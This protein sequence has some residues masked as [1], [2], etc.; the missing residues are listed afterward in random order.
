M[1]RCLACET[2]FVSDLWTCSSCGHVPERRDGHLA[3]AP[4]LAA[5]ADD[6]PVDVFARLVELEESNFWFLGRNR[7]LLWALRRW[8]PNAERI[9]DVGGGTGFVLAAFA[10]ELPH[11]RLTGSELASD[12]LAVAAARVPQA[13]LLQM[14]ARQI[15]FRDEFDLVTACDVIEHID[16]D[17]RVLRELYRA[18]KPGGGLLVT[19]PQHR[20]LWSASDDFARHKRRYTRRELI[21]RVREA[22][23]EVASCLSFVS[24]LL[25]AMILSRLRRRS[26]TSYDPHAEFESAHRLSPLLGP[27]MTV[28]SALIRAGIRFPVGGSLLIAAHRAAGTR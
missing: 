14:D 15:P 23:F 21:A 3:F 5:S 17:A 2:L 13:E 9:L 11:V 27:V 19:V 28:E 26:P 16:D 25:P 7:L 10:R 6:F 8:F 1:K 24:L 20:W 22:G 18:V 12:G 4:E